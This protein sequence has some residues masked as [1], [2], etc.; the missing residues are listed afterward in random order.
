[1]KKILLPCLLVF[2]GAASAQNLSFDDPALKSLLLNTD[3][4][5]NSA[6]FAYDQQDNTIVID[7]NGDGEIQQ[8][9][10]DQVYRI[11][12]QLPVISTL[13]GIEGFTNLDWL[14]CNGGDFASADLSGLAN[15]ERITFSYSGI[16]SLSLNGLIH[17]KNVSIINTPVNTID[18]TGVT[19]IEDL[20][21]NQTALTSFNEPALTT[22]KHLQ[23]DSNLMSSIDLA[24]LANLESLVIINCSFSAVNL[25]NLTQLQEL[26]LKNIQLSAID[27]SPL[28][29]LTSLDLTNNNVTS[30]NLAP[31]PLLSSLLLANN[32]ISA[33]NVSTL[34]LL[35]GVDVSNN[36]LTTLD[37]SA[38]PMLQNVNCSNNNVNYINLKNGTSFTADYIDFTNFSGNDNLEFICVDEPEADLVNLNLQ[39]QG[40]TGVALNT[41]CGLF[42]EDQ[43][44]IA[45]TITFDNEG[46]GCDVDDNTMQLAKV[47]VTNVNTNDIGITYTDIS[48]MYNGI[49]GAGSFA[50]APQFD[51]DLFTVSPDPAI[52]NFDTTDN[53]SFTQDFCV[54]A[55]G[56]HNDI[57]LAAATIVGANPGFPSVYKVVIKN[58]GNQQ[59]AGDVS[60]AFDNNLMYFI[61]ASPSGSINGTGL[62]TFPFTGLMPYESRAFTFT[63]LANPPTDTLPVNIGDVLT[64]T[65]TVT[66]DN[67]ETPE[68]NTITFT[69]TATGSFDPNDITCLE[70]NVA[71]ASSIGNFLRYNINFENTGTAAAQFVVVSVPVD[72]AAFDINSL[73][74][75][76]NS[77]TAVVRVL[78]NSIEYRFNN[79]NLGPE[80][81]ANF[82]FKI[83]TLPSLAVGNSVSMD[84]NIYFDYNWPIATNDAV[85]TLGILGTENNYKPVTKIYPNPATDYITIKTEN[86]VKK[87]ELYTIN[88]RLLTTEMPNKLDPAFSLVNRPSGI[89]FLKIYSDAGTTTQKVIKL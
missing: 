45:G 24:G 47:V 41:Y 79:I 76:Y 54:T 48:G 42:Q 34:P 52:V 84:A 17:L 82:I 61:N 57:E 23:L 27:L 25:S 63:L 73:E 2:A 74:L 39:Q 12:L 87:L 53:S 55:N 26:T 32:Q 36:L 50:I 29:Q 51:A 65:A 69:D 86:I 78:E 83:K 70:G 11:T 9:E 30:I 71:D 6:S 67:D 89:Y 1:M 46:N 8:D 20:Y 68:N 72:A 38:N 88:G 43:N 33:L 19:A 15:L 80:E 40:I 58:N 3:G 64:F 31:V 10:A 4:L 35:T 62:I 22:L 81:K 44:T 28:S 60:F 37:F 77:R 14:I 85:T 5:V 7:A 13:G 56:L 75:I 21:L 18:F 59:A 16:T 49:A 66:T